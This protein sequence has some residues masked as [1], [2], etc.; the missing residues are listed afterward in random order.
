MSEEKKVNWNRDIEAFGE[1]LRERENSPATIEK[2]LRD[3]R[4]FRQYMQGKEILDKNSLLCY[5]A[6]LTDHYR[7]SSVNSMIVALN[8]FL[9]FLEAGRLRI[10]RVKVQCQ[11]FRTAEKELD[12]AEFR[13]LVAN[14]RGCGRSQLAMIMETIGSTGIRI[15]ELQYFRV[16]DIRNGMIRVHNK[17]KYRI[18][19]LPERLRKKLLIYIAKNGIT[20]GPVFCTR[21]GKIKDRSNIWKEMKKVASNAGIDE[22][23]VFPHNLRHLFARIFYKTTN[24]LI[25]L[26]DLLG[27]SSLDVTRIYTNDGLEEWRKSLEKMELIESWQEA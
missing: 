25:H 4:T 12:K 8:Q 10:R 11:R 2:Y 15:S 5:K 6:W 13:K 3:I 14:A 16:K 19:L 22:R 27:H 17:G 1:Y 18:V 26:A 24:N 21:N 23:K 9:M 7:V 20:N